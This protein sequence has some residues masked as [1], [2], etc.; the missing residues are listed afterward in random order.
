M[1]DSKITLIGLNKYLSYDNKGLFDFL[2]VPDGIDKDTL[3]SNILQ[4]GSEFEV[5]YPDA[6]YMRASVGM[7]S[8]KWYWTF[9]KWVKAINIEY[10]PLEN[11][12][13][14]ESW[15]DNNTHSDITD[16]TH[17]ESNKTD[18]KRDISGDNSSNTDATLTTNANSV[19]N[20]TIDETIENTKSAFDSA[21]YSPYEK[22]DRDTGSDTTHSE[23]GYSHN[24]SNEFGNRKEND[25]YTETFTNNGDYK[26]VQNGD[27]E[28]VHEG[29][30]HGNIGIRSSQELLL[31]EIDVAYFSL[32][33]RITDL[34]LTEFCIPIYI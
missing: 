32:Y 23:D 18:S 25:T 3:C 11:Y 12:D 6:E 24:V 27:Y 16:N 34:F 15:T 33:D 5:Q 4:R 14:F 30:L 19:D 29:R 21:T 31:Q 22:S 26:N 10:S 13:R 28:T 1:S 9:D 2:D 7:W 8:K 17:K 20:T